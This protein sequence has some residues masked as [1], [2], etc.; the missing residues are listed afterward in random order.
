ML[1]IPTQFDQV[2][3]EVSGETLVHTS[4]ISISWSDWSLRWLR[5]MHID[6]NGCVI[7]FGFP[8]FMNLE[9]GVN[10]YHIGEKDILSRA[11]NDLYATLKIDGSLLIRYVHNGEVKWRTRGSLTVGLDNKSEISQFCYNNPL[12]ED[13]SIYPDKSILFEW[14]SP[15]NKI[16]IG[17]DYPQIFLVG[18]VEFDKHECWWD[19]RPRLFTMDELTEVSETLKVPMVEWYALNNTDEVTRLIEDLKSN[20]EIE[21][22]VLRFDDCQKMVKVK[23]EHYRTLHALRSNLTTAKLAD[24]WLQW[25]RP[26]FKVYESSFANA[27][28][29]ECWQWAM[30]AVSSMYDG[31]KHANAI[32]KHLVEYVESNRLL[33]RKDF[34]LMSK[35]KYEGVRLSTCFL[36]LDNKNIPDETWKKLVLQNCKQVEMRMFSDKVGDDQ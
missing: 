23:A 25:N 36:L 26:D 34:A 30:P 6:Q 9:E 1:M 4:H 7:S 17:Y 29:Y 10:E 5:S 16:V 24:L 15:L 28:D 11:G 21:G 32:M 18:G 31:I 2:K 20:T 3:D 8:K 22:F 13:P 35:Q 27:Y 12:L 14:V 33:H 19:A